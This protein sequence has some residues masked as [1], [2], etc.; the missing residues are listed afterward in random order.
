MKKTIKLAAVLMAAMMLIV[1]LAGCS[2]KDDGKFTIATN[3]AFEPFEFVDDDGEFAGFDMEM[4][5]YIADYLGEEL[6]VENMAFD[7]VVTAVATGKVDAGI[8]C[9]TI[10]DERK[11]TVNFSNAYYATSQAIVVASNSDITDVDALNGTDIGVQLGTTGDI[12][13]SDYVDCTVHQYNNGTEAGMDLQNGKID[14]IVIDADPAAK[15]AANFGFVVLEKPLTDEEIGI[16]VSKDNTELLKK[17]D[18]A[19]E[20]MKAEGKYEELL[21]KYGLMAEAE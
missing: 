13:V 21:K 12:F 7:G 14:A 11:K 5:Q 17:I 4:A 20:Q 1:S 2:N 6:V 18:A 19:V 3:A 8:A 16:A 15:I 9:I 10:N